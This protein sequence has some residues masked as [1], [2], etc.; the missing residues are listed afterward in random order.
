MPKAPPGFATSPAGASR[1]T[2]RI[3]AMATELRKLGATVDE[4]P[5]YIQVTPPATL[6]SMEK[7]HRSTPTTTTASLCAFA[8]GVQPRGRAGTY[9]KTPSA[10][11]R[12]FR[13]ISKPCSPLRRRR[14]CGH[15]RVCVDGPTASGK[16]TLAAAVAQKLGYHLLDSGRCTASPPWPP[17]A[18]NWRRA[19]A[20][21]A[22]AA[23]S[24]AAGHPF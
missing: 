21:D 6:D 13:T 3:V 4:G 12:P 15:S 20:A 11:P 9:S 17:C 5:D 7:Q 8:S 10:W 2:D 19:P 1:E 18:P 24:A 16:G 23:L 22:I 14:H